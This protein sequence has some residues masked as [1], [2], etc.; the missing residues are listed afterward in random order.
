MFQHCMQ[1]AFYQI[2]ADRRMLD[3]IELDLRTILGHVAI[4]FESQRL[5][6]LSQLAC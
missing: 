5:G 6:W 1:F 3:Q 2:P 4:K